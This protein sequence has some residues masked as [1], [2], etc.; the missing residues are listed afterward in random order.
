M[1]LLNSQDI[2]EYYGDNKYYGGW[3][4]IDQLNFNI[5]NNKFYIINFGEASSGGTHWCLIYNVKKS[6]TVYFDPFG[7]APPLRILDFMKKNNPK[8]V[9]MSDQ[10]IQDIDSVACGYYCLYV[11]DE[12]LKNRDLLDIILLDFN[13]DRQAN[14]DT[15]NNFYNR[16]R[17]K[18]GVSDSGVDGGSISEI[19]RIIFLG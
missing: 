12:L 7:L 14:E 19:T 17:N 6:F 2:D 8:Q 11:I 10:W 1:I 4:S 16:V 15:I 13:I 9:V 5:K 3:F 18:L